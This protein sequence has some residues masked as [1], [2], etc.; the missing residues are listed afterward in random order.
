ME[1]SGN[2]QNDDDRKLFAGGLAQEATEKDIM[3]YFGTFGEVASVNLKMDQMTGRSRGFAFVVFTE[4]ETLTKVLSQDH[5]IKGK[6]VAVKKAA[7]KQGKIYIGKFT[8]PTISEEVSYTI[9]WLTY[10]T[11]FMY[12]SFT[13]IFMKISYFLFSIDYS[14]A[15]QAIRRSC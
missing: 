5:A 6:K 4:V 10:S 9:V 13:L 2:Q 8:D 7:S 1:T 3:E 11:Y 14:R 12:V 15:F